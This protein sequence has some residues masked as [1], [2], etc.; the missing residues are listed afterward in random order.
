MIK[1]V[2]NSQTVLDALIQHCGSIESL[3]D[4]LEKNGKT[5]ITFTPTGEYDFPEEI[6]EFVVKYFKSSDVPATADLSIYQPPPIIYAE[7]ESYMNL[8]GIPNTE[9][10]ILYQYTPQQITGN[11]CWM[12]VNDFIGFLKDTGVWDQLFA[13]Y[14]FIG[15][16]ADGH[17][18]N[19]KNT[20]EY[21]IEWFGGVSHSRFGVAFN[22]ST[23]YGNTG[24]HNPD[25]LPAVHKNHLSMYVR[26]SFPYSYPIG[27]GHQGFV[28]NGMFFLLDA[29]N[30]YYSANGDNLTA[31]IAN[32][33]CPGWYCAT[34][35][36]TLTLNLY[37][38]HPSLPS[39]D[40]LDYNNPGVIPGNIFVGCIN[41]T[42]GADYFTPVQMMNVT[43]GSS[44]NESQVNN[45]YSA[46]ENLQ[47][48]LK[49]NI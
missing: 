27:N 22:G 32:N 8:L 48:A 11:E 5:N 43:I 16:S 36:N 45:L 41:G 20:S 4:F 15:S 9:E 47:I 30:L 2:A 13:I 17:S 44:L 34:R 33:G 19:L 26:N 21:Y 3:F 18:L 39:I 31:P 42:G 38:R 40:R 49:R 23:G 10:F 29:T 12:A 46:I 14:L 35:S 24:F 28:R 7:T 1:S 37:K 6:R 25:N